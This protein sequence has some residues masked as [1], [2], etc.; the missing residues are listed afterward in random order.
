MYTTE[1]GKKKLRPEYLDITDVRKKTGLATN[2]TYTW[3]DYDAHLIPAT[4]EQRDAYDLAR[5]HD[6]VYHVRPQYIESELSNVSLLQAAVDKH[7]NEQITKFILGQRSMDE[8]DQ[9]VS[10][11]KKIGVDELMK[12][13]QTAYDRLK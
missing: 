11:A 13:T 2:G 1:N 10:E 7:R 6:S 12:I 4:Q 8:W 5:K 9:Y 3:F